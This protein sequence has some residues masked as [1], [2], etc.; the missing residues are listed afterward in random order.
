LK[1]EFDGQ[2]MFANYKQ[3]R[4]RYGLSRN[5]IKKL[6][7]SGKVRT[8]KLTPE[9]SSQRL[10]RVEDIETFLFSKESRNSQLTGLKV[11]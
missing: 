7:D 4:E 8:V 10:F 3:V 1:G 6:S 11:I 5:F 2:F 9:K